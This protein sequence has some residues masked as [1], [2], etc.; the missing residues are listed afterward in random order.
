MR[1]QIIATVFAAAL[2]APLAA[3]A[4][5]VN[6]TVNGAQRGAAQGEN[7]AGP[8]GGVVGGAIGAGVGAVTGAVGTA[9]GIVGDVLG[10][11]ER[12]R[13]REYVVREHRPSYR[14]ADPLR[15]GAV[16]PRE[17]VTYYEVPSEYVTRP[18]Y[19]YTV[20]NERPVIVDPATRQVVE[21]LD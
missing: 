12:P 9:T 6:G 16:L 18:G 10:A 2:V 8:V 20:V 11:G 15:V 5:V 7:A 4:Q 13:F 1:N 3:Q 14:Y 19:R 21:V 17:G